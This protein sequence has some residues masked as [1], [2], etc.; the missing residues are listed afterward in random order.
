VLIFTSIDPL[1]KP[2][3]ALTDY[4]ADALLGFLRELTQKGVGFYTSAIS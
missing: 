2:A 4:E 1:E 3:S